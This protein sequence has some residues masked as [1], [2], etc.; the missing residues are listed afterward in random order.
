MVFSNLPRIGLFSGF[1]PLP[2]LN[3]IFKFLKISLI[4]SC[5]WPLQGPLPDGILG[6]GA[7]LGVFWAFRGPWLPWPLSPCFKVS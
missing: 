6:R 1:L 5:F 7:F 2:L 3:G 4:F